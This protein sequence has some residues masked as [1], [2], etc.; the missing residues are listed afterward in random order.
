MYPNLAT[1]RRKIAC[2][3]VLTTAQALLTQYVLELSA[4]GWVER[5]YPLTAEQPFTEWLTGRIVLHKTADG[6]TEAFYCNRRLEG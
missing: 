5:L 6:H 4:E 3:E 2:N 1:H